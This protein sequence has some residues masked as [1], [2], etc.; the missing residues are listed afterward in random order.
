[1]AVVLQPA[2]LDNATR[3]RIQIGQS[4]VQAGSMQGINLLT[5][6]HLR[7][8]L[9]AVVRE[10]GDRSETVFVLNRYFKA[11]IAP[12]HADF[13]FA[14]ILGAYGELTCDVVNL[15]GIKGLPVGSHAP[16]VEEELAL[17][18]GGGHLDQPP[19][20]NDVFVNFGLDPMNGEGNQ[21]HATGRVK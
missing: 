1:T 15:L 13:H 4:I 20:T 19:V 6:E 8:L 18:L 21:T 10:P 2:G 11:H 12:G 5:L 17:R 16:E 9:V 14:D 3:T 7:R